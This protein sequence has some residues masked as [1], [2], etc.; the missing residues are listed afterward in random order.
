MNAKMKFCRMSLGILLA[1]VLL[2]PGPGRA[3]EEGM[4]PG[5]GMPRE[6]VVQELN[7]PPDKADKFLAVSDRYEKIR[8]KIIAGIKKD[9]EELEKALSAPQPDEKRIKDLVASVT[10]CH[11]QLFETFKVQRHEEMA[12]LNPLQQGKFVIALKRWHQE[13]RDKYERQRAEE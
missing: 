9:E 2:M 6:R 5:L 13:M 12:L 1:A 4:S 11:D 8:E 3:E 10:A 7:L